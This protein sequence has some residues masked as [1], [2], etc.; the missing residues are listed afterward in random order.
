M[1]NAAKALSIAGGILIALIIFA[2]LI[3][4][5][6]RMSQIPDRQNFLKEVEEMEEFNRQFEAYQKKLM[7]GVDVISCLN[8]VIDNNTKSEDYAY[9]RYNVKIEITIKSSIEDKVEVWYFDDDRGKKPEERILEKNIDIG[10]FGDIFGKNFATSNISNIK[11][12]TNINPKSEY[13]WIEVKSGKKTYIYE[14]SKYLTDDAK[15]LKQLSEDTVNM[16]KV[17]TNPNKD[18]I[19]NWSKVIWY[20]SAYNFKNKKFKCTGITYNDEGRI[21]SISFEEYVK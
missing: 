18:D 11:N 6:R 5:F 9:G 17:A 3:F 1:E 13:I 10:T 4:T 19:R 7:Y 2:S 21:N 20:T 16:Q 14:N 12:Y 8:K 15:V